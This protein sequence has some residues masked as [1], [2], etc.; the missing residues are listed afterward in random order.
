MDGIVSSSRLRSR[1]SL[2]TGTPPSAAKSASCTFPP[3]SWCKCV[4]TSSYGAMA[5]LSV[6]FGYFCIPELKNKTLE[7]VEK[8]FESRVPLRKLGEL[9]VPE[10]EVAAAIRSEHEAELAK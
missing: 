8:M 4:L 3:P 9:D 6:I 2:T 5:F 10:N 1:T 7:Q